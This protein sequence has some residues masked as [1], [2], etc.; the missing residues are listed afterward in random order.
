MG[1]GSS[2]F[3]KSR[4]G[5]GLPYADHAVLIERLWEGF[6]GMSLQLPAF[7]PVVHM[8]F[9]MLAYGAAYGVSRIRLSGLPD[10]PTLSYEQRRWLLLAA[11]IGAIVGAKGI[12]WLNYPGAMVDSMTYALHGLLPLGLMSGKG[13]VGGL[14]GGWLGVECAKKCMKITGSTGDRWVLPLLVGMSVGR[15]GCFLTGFYDQTYGIASSLPWAVDFGDGITRHPTQLYEILWL[16]VVGLLLFKVKPVQQRLCQSGDTFKAFVLAYVL[17]RLGVDVIKPMPHLYAG[18][19][20][21]QWLAIAV[22][23]WHWPVIVRWVKLSQSPPLVSVDP[24]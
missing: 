15:I 7:P 6:I 20:A 24:P 18:L 21:E 9:D 12:H 3:W 10:S 23:C 16:V 4:S 5:Q 17:F 13:V 22:W 2:E 8:L 1:F 11:L 14:L 19:N